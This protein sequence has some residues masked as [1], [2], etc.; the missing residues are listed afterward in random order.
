MPVRCQKLRLAADAMELDLHLGSQ[1]E[2]RFVTDKFAEWGYQVLAVREGGAT[3]PN[4]I[5]VTV[6][7]HDDDGIIE[8][9]CNQPEF[10]VKC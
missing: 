8:K 5:T 4:L 3:S 10:D 1:A 7:G 9:M 2:H 6:S